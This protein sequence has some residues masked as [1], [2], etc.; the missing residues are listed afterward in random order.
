MRQ[1]GD[2]VQPVGGG[3]F[4]DAR[5]V[6][7]DFRSGRVE[8]RKKVEPQQRRVFAGDGREDVHDRLQVFFCESVE[9]QL[10]HDFRIAEVVAE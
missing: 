6:L 9:L 3:V 4:D 5:Q 10:L 7:G 2:V 8:P 1:G